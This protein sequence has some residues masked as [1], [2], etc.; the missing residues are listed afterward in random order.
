MKKSDENAP[1]GVA[2]AIIRDNPVALS[3]NDSLI[4]ENEVTP[5]ETSWDI[6]AIL[7]K[8]PT[9]RLISKP[10]PIINPSIKEWKAKPENAIIPNL[11][12]A[13]WALCLSLS[14]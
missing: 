12:E 5:S 3:G 13:I 6:T 14:L 10:K 11:E 8:V 4:N 2:A 1:T 9:S 7:A